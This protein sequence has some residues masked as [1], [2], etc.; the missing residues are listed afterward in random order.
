M[1]QPVQGVVSDGSFSDIGMAVFVGSERIQTVVYMENGNLVKS[2]DLIEFPENTFV[3][4]DK[5]IFPAIPTWE[6][7]LICDILYFPFRICFLL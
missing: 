2:D 4:M 3:I 6:P 5:I 7:N 1:N